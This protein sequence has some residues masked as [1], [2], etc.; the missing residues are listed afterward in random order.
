MGGGGGG[1]VEL[2]LQNPAP[3]I[4]CYPKFNVRREQYPVIARNIYFPNE[5]IS[6]GLC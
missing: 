6:P 4:F 1:G 2:E 3:V 5:V